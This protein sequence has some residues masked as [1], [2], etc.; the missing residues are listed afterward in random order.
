MRSVDSC[1]FPWCRIGPST[2]D[3]GVDAT[4]SVECAQKVACTIHT[5][6]QR[7]FCIRPSSTT[8]PGAKAPRSSLDGQ[9]RQVPRITEW[10]FTWDRLRDQ[11]RPGPIPFP[12][13]L[14][15]TSLEGN[16][17]GGLLVVQST[18]PGHAIPTRWF[19]P[20]VGISVLCPGQDNCGLPFYTIYVDIYYRI[21]VES[22]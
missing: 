3:L 10:G 9:Y 19:E 21:Y 20:P 8:P 11:A 14:N 17:L 6:C 22:L 15:E 7:L 18:R 13:W 4:G 16:L 5:F 2:C 1:F 12:G